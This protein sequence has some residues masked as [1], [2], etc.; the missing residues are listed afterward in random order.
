MALTYDLVVIGSGPGGYVA[1]L[2]MAAEGKRVAV[3]ENRDLGGVCLNRGCIPT[4]TM[5]H[6]SEIAA[7]IQHAEVHGL[8]VEGWSFDMPTLMKRKQKVVKKLSGGV[9]M[10]LKGRKVDVYQGTGSLADKNTVKVALNKGGEETLSTDA[11]I[12]ATGSE[13]F[14]HSIFP[15]DRTRVMTS[16]EI[17]DI[18]TLPDSLLIVGGGYIGCEFATIFSELGTRV[19]VV[20]MLDGLIPIC[21][22]EISKILAKVMA[23]NG[24]Q[25]HLATKV[26]QMAIQGDVVVTTLESGESIT[27]ALALISTGRMPLSR[28]LGLEQVGVKVEKGYIVI[29]QHCRTNIPNIFA[30]G[31]VTG[32]V[33]LAHV[34]SRQAEVAVNTLLGKKDREDYAIVPSAIYTHPEIGC[35]GLTE[36][37][38][39]TK[40]LAVRTAKFDMMASGMATAYDEN[41]GFVK[42]IADADDVILGAHLMCPHAADIVQE[43]VVMMKSEC[44]L[45]EVAATIHGHPTFCEAVKETAEILLGRP[46]H[47]H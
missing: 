11:I 44:T 31:D 14:V 32:K 27:T 30:I 21:D 38:A 40:G 6:S 5:L 13:P 7:H 28:N 46:L 8:K 1:A 16:D 26:K 39:K 43:I 25:L 15:A 4:K 17:L 36:E 20:E 24:I 47:G 41:T 3:V 10:L 22:L 18:E 45:H 19:T 34:A 37:Q 35:V 2:R 12:V 9:G 29:D 33:Q 23:K 42:L